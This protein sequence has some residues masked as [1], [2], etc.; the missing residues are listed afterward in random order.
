M[1]QVCCEMHAIRQ[2]LVSEWINITYGI[3]QYFVE[4]E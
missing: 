1:H 4:K 2:I 3:E